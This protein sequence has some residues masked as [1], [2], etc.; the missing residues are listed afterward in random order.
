MRGKQ[1]VF[2]ATKWARKNSD[3]SHNRQL[4]PRVLSPRHKSKHNMS[5]GKNDLSRPYATGKLDRII[6]RDCNDRVTSGSHSST[7]KR[8]MSPHTF[9]TCVF[10]NHRDKIQSQR[11]QL[12]HKNVKSVKPP[13]TCHETI[14]RNQKYSRGFVST[15]RSLSNIS[16][17]LSTPKKS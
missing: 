4:E 13:I 1:S 9:S 8:E 11:T 3:P 6:S 17:E 15:K 12:P 5:L 2:S 14:N 10:G 16:S 7:D